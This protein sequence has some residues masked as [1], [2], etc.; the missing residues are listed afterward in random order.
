M[1]N[2]SRFT[3]AVML[4]AIVSS[5]VWTRLYGVITLQQTALTAVIV[6]IALIAQHPMKARAA[7]ERARANRANGGV[8]R[9]YVNEVEVGALPELQYRQVVVDAW[10]RW[11]LYG[12][13]A[14]NAVE[15]G[16]RVAFA[17]VRLI[18]WVW[19][20]LVAIAAVLIPDQLATVFGTLAKGTPA[21]FVVALRSGLGGGA[22]LSAVAVG[23]GVA[24]GGLKFG[25]VNEFD[26]FIA[27]RL[28][29]LLEEPADGRLQVRVGSAQLVS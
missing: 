10:A 9:V 22:L 8:A 7:L 1:K 26:G 5:A 3:A 17:V 19:F 4:T 16:A 24:L 14:L 28:R 11:D 13:Q 6:A 21:E 2:P 25:F 23:G 18:P 20:A 15:V 12:R 27:Q 29:Q